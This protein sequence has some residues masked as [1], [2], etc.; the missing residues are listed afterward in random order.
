MKK[1]GRAAAIGGIA[2]IV[3][4]A[5]EGDWATVGQGINATAQGGTQGGWW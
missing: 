5:M 2:M 1:M 4:G 3:G